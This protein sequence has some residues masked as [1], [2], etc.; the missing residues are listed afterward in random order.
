VRPA[1]SAAATTVEFRVERF[2]V[3][4]ERF[5]VRARFGISPPAATQ[6]EE[7]HCWRFFCWI[8]TM[9]DQM[10]YVVAWILGVPLSVIAVWFII[11]HT[12]CR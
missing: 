11:G 8:I 1:A 6:Q 9:E 12:A 10:R 2:F 4:V 3:R 7:R 5:F